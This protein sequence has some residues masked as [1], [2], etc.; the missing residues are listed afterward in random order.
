M[1]ASR[2]PGLPTK[3]KLQPAEAE[4]CAL[5][6]DTLCC[7]CDDWICASVTITPEVTVFDLSE[8]HLPSSG[9]NLG[10]GW[11]KVLLKCRE[12]RV[13]AFFWLEVSQ[14]HRR[15]WAVG[16]W[17]LLC[18][19]AGLAQAGQSWCWCSPGVAGRACGMSCVSLRGRQGF[20][21]EFLWKVEACG[22]GDVC[23][24]GRPRGWLAC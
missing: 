19:S 8:C 13:K 21:Q 12:E 16:S 9:L 6:P 3:S 7:K 15:V 14:N 11:H 20:P 17:F 22:M 2:C 4:L 23:E 5:P 10:E 18:I 24:E 1:S